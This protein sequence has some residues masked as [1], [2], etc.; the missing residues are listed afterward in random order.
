LRLEETH[1]RDHNEAVRIDKAAKEL[2]DRLTISFET[3]REHILYDWAYFDLLDLQEGKNAME[4]SRHIRKVVIDNREY[5]LPNFEVTHHQLENN[6]F[7]SQQKARME[8]ERILELKIDRVLREA[9]ERE[10]RVREM[11]GGLWWLDADGYRGRLEIRLKKDGRFD[12]RL[13]LDTPPKGKR[14]ARASNFRITGQYKDNNIEFARLAG[15][16]SREIGRYKGT[17]DIDEQT[18]AGISFFRRQ[19]EKE[20][21][22]CGKW[23]ADKE[24]TD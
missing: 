10:R 6:N 14:R 2:A 19:N 16:P 4:T 18:I 24:K 1:S 17:L 11:L 9:P 21:R 12:G 15:W 22:H 7:V 13:K 5:K 8:M 20:W 23:R 3:A